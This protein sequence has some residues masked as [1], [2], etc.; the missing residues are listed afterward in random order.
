VPDRVL[1]DISP[2]RKERALRL[3][4]LRRPRIGLPNVKTRQP[5]P[6]AIP[7]LASGSARAG[8]AP[9][10]LPHPARRHREALSLVFFSMVRIWAASRRPAT[11]VLRASLAPPQAAPAFNM[12]VR[13]GNCRSHSF[14]PSHKLRLLR[15][16]LLLISP[17]IFFRSF[18]KFCGR[19]FQFRLFPSSHC[20]WRSRRVVF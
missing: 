9:L 5:L 17:V 19:L 16:A 11:N 18:R 7:E 6:A 13:N 1:R 2:R 8:L 10:W 20:L 14:P 15:H 3:L 12:Y 4:I